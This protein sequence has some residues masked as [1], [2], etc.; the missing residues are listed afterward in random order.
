M[1]P[2]PPCSKLLFVSVLIPASLPSQ[3]FPTWLVLQPHFLSHILWLLYMSVAETGHVAGR[4]WS[5]SEREKANYIP[6]PQAR[7]LVALRLRCLWLHPFVIYLRLSST[8]SLVALVQV[9]S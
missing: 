5:R 9:I 1:V 2:S 6:N 8:L 7:D 3:E 4:H